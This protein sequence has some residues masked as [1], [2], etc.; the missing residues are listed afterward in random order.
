MVAPRSRHG[1]ATVAPR[2]YSA[3]PRSASSWRAAAGAGAAHDLLCGSDMR[4]M[5]PSTRLRSSAP[6]VLFALLAVGCDAG[7]PTPPDRADMTAPDMTKRTDD[8]AMPD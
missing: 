8:F 3:R 2:T 7:E 1:R 6:F 5:P 4:P